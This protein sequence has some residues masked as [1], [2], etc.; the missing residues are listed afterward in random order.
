MPAHVIYPK[1]DARP[2]GFS[3]KWLNEILRGTLGFGGAVFSDDLSMEGARVLDGREVTYTEAAL[4][5]LNAG[6]DMVLLCNQSVESVGSGAPIDELLDGMS[7]ALLKD[8][9]VPNEV[10]DQRRTGLLPMMPA[11]DWDEL[12]VSAQYMQALECLP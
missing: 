12:M 2:A 8:L 1:V 3:A 7:E 6:C 11:L 10:S 9:W 4:A 5:A